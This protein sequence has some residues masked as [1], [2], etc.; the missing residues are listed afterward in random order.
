[1]K[2]FKYLGTALCQHGSV[3]GKVRDREVKGS[4]VVGTLERI[5]KGR[6]VSMEVR[7]GIK[8]SIILPTFLQASETWTW[9]VAITNAKAVEMSYLRGA[10]GVKMG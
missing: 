10:C 4:Q 8:N 5:M 9:N 2:E 1:M 3:E 7:K 6:S